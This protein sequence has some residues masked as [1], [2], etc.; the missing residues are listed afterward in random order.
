LPRGKLDPGRNPKRAGLHPIATGI[1]P[2]ANLLD[3]L[4]QSA[5]EVHIAAD[6]VRS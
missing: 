3:D 4:L 5:E 6:P 2:P 1:A